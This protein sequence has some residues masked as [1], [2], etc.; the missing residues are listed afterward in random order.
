MDNDRFTKPHTSPDV[1]KQQQLSVRIAEGITKFGTDCSERKSQGA[2]SGQCHY[3][4][5]KRLGDA[6]H[7]ARR[8]TA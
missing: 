7:F 6:E 2:K 4:T 5:S 3:K 1:V 8:P